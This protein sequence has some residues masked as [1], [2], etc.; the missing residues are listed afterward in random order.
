MTDSK[1]VIKGTALN[2][3]QV[4]DLLNLDG[5]SVELLVALP[6]LPAGFYHFVVDSCEVGS[7]GKAGE[8][9]AAIVTVLTI[10]GVEALDNLADQ[11]ILDEV[12]LT[13]NPVSYKENFGLQTKDGYGIRSF[14][15]FTAAWAEATGNAVVMS[16]IDNLAGSVGVCKLDVNRYLPQGKADAPENYK[17]NNRLNVRQVIWS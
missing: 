2:D 1:V 13:S 15:T 16:R 11:K 5:G 3:M 8:E 6:L 9:K 7:T 14:C 12:D 17:E 10:T 4:E